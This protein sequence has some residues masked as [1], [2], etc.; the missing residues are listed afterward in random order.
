MV[1]A[2]TGIINDYWAEALTD[3]HTIL[4]RIDGH[5]KVSSDR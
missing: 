2:D 3:I 1:A 5:Y 4:R